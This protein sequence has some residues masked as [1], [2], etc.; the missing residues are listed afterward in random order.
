MRAYKKYLVSLF[1]LLVCATA[2]AQELEAVVKAGKRVTELG[3]KGAVVKWVSAAD[4]DIYKAVE[5]TLGSEINNALWQQA[6][7]RQIG[8]TPPIVSSAQVSEQIVS[9]L[10]ETAAVKPRIS[11]FSAKYAP[12]LSTK[13][14]ENFK[15]LSHQQA[16]RE[17]VAARGAQLPKQEPF[18]NSRVWFEFSP[19]EFNQLTVGESRRIELDYSTAADIM[20]STTVREAGG[21]Y[22]WVPIPD[23]PVPGNGRRLFR[24]MSLRM[25][26]MSNILENGLRLSD[27]EKYGTETAGNLDLLLGSDTRKKLLPD[28]KSLIWVT[29]T[30]G[31]AASH[32]EKYYNVGMSPV[33][34]TINPKYTT[35]AEQGSPIIR[36]QPGPGYYTVAQDIPASDINHMYVVVK[37]P[38]WNFNAPLEQNQ[39]A[40]HN[41]IWCEIKFDGNRV[42]LSPLPFLK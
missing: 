28:V 36:R 26:K 23:F 7:S 33:V 16:L 38:G 20:L 35:L 21:V 37:G 42:L 13:Y 22:R 3:E 18:P 11:S 40:V 25:D 4:K 8:L 14:L 29:T 15:G 6:A 5:K 10:K 39:K 31:A 17:V 1:S 24:G 19:E 34:V 27:A 41:F 32:A 9:Q 12:G 2:F 30:P